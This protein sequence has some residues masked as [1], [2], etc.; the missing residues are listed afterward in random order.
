MI[1]LTGSFEEARFEAEL[2]PR[3]SIGKRGALAAI[4]G[5]G[6]ILGASTGFM[7]IMSG[8]KTLPYTTPFALAIQMGL[9]WAFMSN[10]RDAC[11]RQVLRLDNA[12]LTLTHTRP[13]W[14]KP[15]VNKMGPA[16][17][18]WVRIK[19]TEI[20]GIKKLSLCL[21]KE[22]MPLGRFLPPVETENLQ[23]NLRLA[24]RNWTKD[25]SPVI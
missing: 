15:V 2:I 20:R 19:E 4:G 22:E 17:L 21:R 25:P 5:T 23:K 3:R 7:G 12:G 24:L 11:E 16:E 1:N 14:E 6:I 18:P 9:T 13:D 8:G 10:A